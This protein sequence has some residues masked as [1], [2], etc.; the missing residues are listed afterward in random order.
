MTSSKRFEPDALVRTLERQLEVTTRQQVLTAGLTRHA[1]EHRLR[2][3][4][5]WHSLLPGV[6]L[7]ATGTPTTLQQE[8]AALLY[9][10]SGSVITGPA[11]LHRHHIRAELTDLVDV[12]VP[13]S[14]KRRDARFVRLHR[15]TRMPDRI[16]EIGPV[17]YAMPA[18]AVA[19]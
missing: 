8:M 10:G 1:L 4:G 12:L 13:A 7:A 5:P 16:C 19:D 15:T 3:G 11:A 2:P 18:R 9:A 17:R 14:R 6:Y